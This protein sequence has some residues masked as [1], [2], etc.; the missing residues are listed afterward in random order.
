MTAEKIIVTLEGTGRGQYVATGFIN[1]QEVDF[2]VDTGATYV[3]IPTK[4]AEKIGA[5]KERKTKLHTA[6]GLTV[7]WY[8]TLKTVRIGEIILHDVKGT[9]SDNLSGEILL[10]SSFLRRLSISQENDKMTITQYR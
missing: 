5:E 3:S 1:N 9:I 7:A 8:T 10:G 6:N 4:I 2:L